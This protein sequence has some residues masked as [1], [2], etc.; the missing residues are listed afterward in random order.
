MAGTEYESDPAAES[1]PYFMRYMILIKKLGFLSHFVLAK[2]S[3]MTVSGAA[4]FPDSERTV[5]MSIA[6]QET[7]S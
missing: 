4:I 6:E 2:L 1:G 5:F 3:V 7:S